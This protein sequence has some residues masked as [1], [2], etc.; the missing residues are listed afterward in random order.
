MRELSM[1]CSPLTSA[2]LRPALLWQWV[3]LVALHTYGA[4]TW[5]TVHIYLSISLASSTTQHQCTLFSKTSRI[6][7]SIDRWLLLLKNR[8]YNNNKYMSMKEQKASMRLAQ[9]H[10]SFTGHAHFATPNKISNCSYCNMFILFGRLSFGLLKL[11]PSFSTI[12]P[13]CGCGAQHKRFLR[14]KLKVIE[15]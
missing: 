5:N 2:L 7:Q 9:A 1:L 4:S 14:E 15:T 11:F 6:L 3:A 13:N 12:C 8:L 10:S